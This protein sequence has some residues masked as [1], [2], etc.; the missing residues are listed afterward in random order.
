MDKI[1]DYCKYEGKL[2]RN[3]KKYKMVLLETNTFVWEP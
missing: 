3:A 1:E 2:P